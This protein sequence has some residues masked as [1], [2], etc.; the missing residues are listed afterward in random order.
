MKSIL[1]ISILCLFLLSSRAQEY[2]IQGRISDKK[3]AKG[4]KKA[5]LSLYNSKD[6]LIAETFSDRK[7][8]Y[9]LKAI[10]HEKD[11]MLV[12][13]KEY[14]VKRFVSIPVGRSATGDFSMERKTPA[15]KHSNSLSAFRS[16]REYKS[17]Q[18]KAEEPKAE[19]KD[20]KTH[21]TVKTTLI[22]RSRRTRYFFI[23]PNCHLV[24]FSLDTMALALSDNNECKSYEQTVFTLAAKAEFTVE[25]SLKA[26]Q[27][28]TSPMSFRMVMFYNSAKNKNEKPMNDYFKNAFVLFSNY[29]KI[30]ESLK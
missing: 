2:C 12:Q 11:Y 24:D 20:G 22:N 14:E 19:V 6:S 7:G 1:H 10:V 16:Y 17:L 30:E 26:A 4:I 9:K 28:F 29:I 3:T 13:K 21:W 8:R 25:L 23:S 27:P 5:K 18:L 15:R